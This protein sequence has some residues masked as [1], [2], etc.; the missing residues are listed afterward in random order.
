MSKRATLTIT[1]DYN[2]NPDTDTIEDLLHNLARLAAGNGLL[3]G[4]GEITIDSWDA[5]VKVLPIPDEP[6]DDDSGPRVM[7][8]FQPQADVDDYAMDIDGAYEFDVTALVEKMG[9][10]KALRIEDGQLSSD[11]LWRDW[12]ANHPDKD[13]DGPFRVTVEEAIE[14]YF[15]AL[16]N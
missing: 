2:E 10:K 13:H 5:D 14:E 12:V 15:A 4:D 16:K 11:E 9:R 1:V 8:H 6:V 3:S 7:A